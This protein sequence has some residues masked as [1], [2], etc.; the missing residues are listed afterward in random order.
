MSTLGPRL[1]AIALK[2]LEFPRILSPSFTKDV[3]VA[4]VYNSET[5]R[6]YRE[7]VLWLENTKIRKLKREGGERE[8][9]LSETLEDEAWSKNYEAYLK[10][11]ECDE[12]HLTC[13]ESKIDFLINLALAEEYRDRFDIAEEEEER[14]K[15]RRRERMLLLMIMSE[16]KR[17]RERR[18]RRC[19]GWGSIK[20]MVVKIRE[21]M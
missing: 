3:C 16:N 5:S 15:R 21:R 8:K 12:T 10:A 13:A 9:L 17:E 11:C 7:L 1:H 14:R 6:E 4:S 20:T 19:E 2:A 18:R